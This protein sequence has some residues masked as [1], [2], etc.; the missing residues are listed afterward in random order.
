MIAAA[1]KAQ[2]DAI[3]KKK[4]DKAKLLDDRHKANVETLANLQKLL[5]SSY[6]MTGEQ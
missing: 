3:D 4:A 5:V 1:E 6:S 2:R